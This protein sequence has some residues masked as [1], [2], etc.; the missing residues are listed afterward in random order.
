[1][2]DFKP[3]NEANFWIITKD[4]NWFMRI[5]CNGEIPTTRQLKY[6]ADIVRSLNK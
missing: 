2:F 1:M 3:D 5:Q 4:N 6:I